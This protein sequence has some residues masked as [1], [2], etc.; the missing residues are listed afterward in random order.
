LAGRPEADPL[1]GRLEAA[2]LL[3]VDVDELARARALVA[4]GRLEAEPA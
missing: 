4:N 1:A 3:D 2:K